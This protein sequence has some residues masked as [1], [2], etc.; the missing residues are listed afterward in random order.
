MIISLNLLKKFVDLENITVDEFVQ[1]LTFSGLEVET[2]S[3]L[4]KATGLVIGEILEVE[5]H[6]DSNHLHVLKVD[7]GSK[8][9]IKQIVCGAPNVKEHL[10]VIVA[11]EG[12]VIGN[13]NVKIVKGTIRGVDSFGMCCSLL[14]LGVDKALLS[15]KQ[16]QGIEELS[17]DAP[18]GEENVLE[19]LGLDDVL[20]EINVLANRSDCLSIYSIAKEVSALFNR[21]LKINKEEVPSTIKSS[22]TVNSLTKN[23]EQFALRVVNNIKVKESPSWLKNALRSEGIRSINNIVDIG[24]YV[25]LLTGRPLHMYDLTKVKTNNF[26]VRDDIEQDFVALDEKTYQVKKDDIVVTDGEEILCLG[27]IM[28]GLSSSVDENTTKIGIECATFTSSRVRRTSSRIGIT[29]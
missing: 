10:H 25:M 29:R 16:T 19:Y 2:V 13:D 26:V 20:I 21:E 3:T 7:L 6:P 14:E 8:R 5:E 18:V 11:T 1:K 28:G 15:D 23:C 12:A 4:A 22:Y 27:G 24:N 17:D 9:G